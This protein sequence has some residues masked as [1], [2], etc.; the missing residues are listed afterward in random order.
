MAAPF[1]FFHEAD[2][3]TPYSAPYHNPYYATPQGGPSPFLPPHP[4]PYSSPY[5]GTTDLPNTF[6]PNS[7]L[8]PESAAEHQS[9]YA[10]SWAPLQPRQRTISW[11]APTAPPSS[12]FLAPTMPAF[13]ANNPARPTHRRQTR[14]WGTA[15]SWVNNA[16]PF[17][18]A[19]GPQAAMQ[20]HPWLNGDAPSPSF[21]FDLAPAAFVPLRRVDTYPPTSALVGPADLRE[22]AFHPPLFALRILHPRLPFW[23]VDLALPTGAHAPPITLADVLVA[24]H[25]A[26]HTRINH[27]DWAT[28]GREDEAAVTRAFAARCRAEAV[29][30]GAAPAHLRD[31]EVAV[32]NQGVKR[33]DF[34][35]GKT[36]FKGLVRAPGDPDG[37]VRMVTA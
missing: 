31:R 37:C 35:V 26:L 33:I 7:V 20:I 4:L 21:H 1:V 16:N 29:R 28:L 2:P 8:W 5:H 18:S 10:P 15:P 19:G 36:V 3:S 27:A 6:D 17:L 32:R 34:L 24:L 23:P 11:H 9:P 30:S 14:S 12:P 22:P 25:R 13:V